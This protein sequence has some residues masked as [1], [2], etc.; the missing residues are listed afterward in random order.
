[1]IKLIK[2]AQHI[3]SLAISDGIMGQ[4]KKTSPIKKDLEENHGFGFLYR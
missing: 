1:L 3:V 2:V 4:E